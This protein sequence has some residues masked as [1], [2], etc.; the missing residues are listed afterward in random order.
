MGANSI[1]IIFGISLTLLFVASSSVAALLEPIGEIYEVWRKKVP[2][3]GNIRAGLVAN[4][5][6]ENLHLIFGLNF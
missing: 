1:R 5:K 6:E 3:A 2:V 4:P